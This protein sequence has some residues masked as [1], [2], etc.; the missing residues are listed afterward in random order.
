[1]LNYFF[2]SISTLITQISVPNESIPQEPLVHEKIS[3][4]QPGAKFEKGPSSCKMPLDVISS[5]T[6]KRWYFQIDP[7][8]YYFTDSQMRRFFDNGGFTFRLETGYRFWGPMIVWIDAGYFQKEGSSIGGSKKVKLK[9]GTLTLGLKG[10]YHFNSYL[11]I[12]G[13]AGPRLFMMM[14]DND[15]PFV[16][17]EDNEI[18]IGGGFDAGFWFFPISKWPNFFIDTFVD[19]SWKKMKIAADQISS[20]DFD[21]DISGISAGLGIGVR[22]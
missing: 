22:F 11:A 7:G 17:G 20:L 1:M 16:R 14:I 8:Y 5:G 18:G 4:A 3:I 9:L 12:Y 2:A 6:E 21:V 15:S 19:Y 10:I 13:G